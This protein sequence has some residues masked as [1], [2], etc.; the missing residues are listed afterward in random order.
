MMQP[1]TNTRFS[2]TRCSQLFLLTLVA[3]TCACCSDSHTRVPDPDGDAETLISPI[4][5]LQVEGDRGD[6]NLLI[7]T[8]ADT[9]PIIDLQLEWRLSEQA[10]QPAGKLVIP[11]GG[12]PPRAQATLIW[13]S[14]IDLLGQQADVDLRLT[15][16]LDDGPHLPIVLS[17]IHIDNTFSDQEARLDANRPTPIWSSS[18]ALSKTDS[19]ALALVWLDGRFGGLDV[20]SA[21]SYDGGQTWGDTDYR[22]STPAAAPATGPLAIPLTNGRTF[23][24]WCSLENHSRRLL[25]NVLKPNGQPQYNVPFS[26]SPE[27]SELDKLL[28]ADAQAAGDGATVAWA[29][30]HTG[31]LRVY[32]AT[33]ADLDRGMGETIALSPLEDMDIEDAAPSLAVMDNV[34]HVVWRRSGD[35][36]AI[37]H[38]QSSDS[39]LTWSDNE[40]VIIY[41]SEQISANGHGFSICIMQPKLLTFPDAIPRVVYVSPEADHPGI[42]MVQRNEDG[43]WTAPTTLSDLTAM[44]TESLAT[45]QSSTGVTALA[46]M[47]RRHDVYDIYAILID[48]KG[49]PLGPEIRLDSGFLDDNQ[50]SYFPSISFGSGRFTFMWRDVD[51]ETLQTSLW[52]ATLALDGTAT[53]AVKLVDEEEVTELVGNYDLATQ[54]S[55]SLFAFDDFRRGP[56]GLHLLRLSDDDGLQELA[57]RHPSDDLLPNGHAIFPVMAGDDGSFS[58]AWVGIHMGYIQAE[59]TEI[60]SDRSSGTVSVLPGQLADQDTRAVRLARDSNGDRHFL[61]ERDSENGSQVFHVSRSVKKGWSAPILLNVTDQGALGYRD[62]Q[63]VSFPD[64]PRLGAAW[65]DTR[66]GRNG[67]FWRGF[68]PGSLWQTEQQLNDGLALD[69]GLVTVSSFQVESA[70][71]GLVAAAWLGASQGVYAL[72]VR[73]SIDYGQTFETT[74]RLVMRDVGSDTV[75]DFAITHTGLMVLA[76][77]TESPGDQRGIFF[78]RSSDG[79]ETWDDSARSVVVGDRDWQEPSLLLTSDGRLTITFWD[80][81]ENTNQSHFYVVHSQD[82]GQSF[83]EHQHLTSIDGTGGGQHLVQL[84]ERPN[85][86]RALLLQ[87]EEREQARLHLYVSPDGGPSWEGPYAPA[88]EDVS[89]FEATLACPENGDLAITYG[90]MPKGFEEIHYVRQP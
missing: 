5:S 10:W 60:R 33:S 40:A 4:E 77:A 23:V 25:A 57:D 70:A 78:V 31:A 13:Y 20:M 3:L 81:D 18:P 68:A 63:L 90:S 89:A 26:V 72:Y 38:R 66:N 61:F 34:Q 71:S 8:P 24:F 41:P 59:T 29:D 17:S 58:I 9:A 80:V 79:G 55:V 49:E 69:G 65:I 14:A 32:T 64:M 47:D 87:D 15:P 12:I 28:D 30:D 39:G 1:I 2:L 83:G 19:G 37:R 51:L 27:L 43:A 73:S 7:T 86:Q 44:P 22:L 53:P 21:V 45:A 62:A 74:D 75:Y 84:C 82:F 52:T 16:I 6:I 11:A 50:M 46:W 35:G 42:M 36:C 76:I 54:S 85:R 67:L 56:S 88:G 48:A